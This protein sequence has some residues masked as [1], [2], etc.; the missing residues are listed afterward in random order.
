M[1]PLRSV[2]TLRSKHASEQVNFLLS[3]NAYTL[4]LKIPLLHLGDCMRSIVGVRERVRVGRAECVQQRREHRISILNAHCGGSDVAGII[5]GWQRV[6]NIWDRES[7]PSVPLNTGHLLD[8]AVTPLSI[9]A[10]V[11]SIWGSLWSTPGP[12]R[13]RP[14]WCFCPVAAEEQRGEKSSI[15][16]LHI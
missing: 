12:W 6:W 8:V 2:Q 10:H 3:S 15:D 16:Q 14:A 11:P 4:T 13:G 1:H 7:S 9:G 5:T